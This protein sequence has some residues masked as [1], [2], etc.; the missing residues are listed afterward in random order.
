MR[1]KTA[2]SW[3][4]LAFLILPACTGYRGLVEEWKEYK[5]PEFYEAQVA[6][7][8]EAGIPPTPPGVDFQK[9]VAQLRE[10]KARWEKT[11]EETGAEQGF[12]TPDPD[13]LK[14]LRPASTDPAAAEKNLSDGFSLE[15]LETLAFLRNPGAK[16]A[17][18]DLRA[19]LEEYS[20]VWNLDEIL[21]QYSA[22]TEALMTG[23]GPMKGQEPVELKFPFPGVLALKGEIVTQE[24]KGMN[25]TLE[26]ARRTAVTMARQA[27]WNLHYLHRAQEI[28]REMVSLLTRL[29]AVASARYE[30]GKA[31][32][33]DVIKV[34][35]EREILEEDLNTLRQEEKN[36]KVKVLEVL[37][38][39]AT[40]KVG[41][42]AAR[43]PNRNV[44]PLDPLYGE[45]IQKRQEVLRLR[46]R[47]GKVE[48][49]I[50]LGETQI[51]PA[52]ALNLSLFEDEA[53]TQVGSFRTK[54][55]FSETTKASVGAGLPKTPWYGK[56]DA[57]LRETRQKLAALREELKKAEEATLFNVREA[58]FRL[59]RA[60]REEALY[61]GQV[62]KLSQAALEVSTRG[63]ETGSVS[64]ADVIASYMN[65]LKANL[66]LAKERS[67]LGTARA[68]L[69]EAVG[70]GWKK[71]PR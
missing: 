65:W 13:L 43:E 1:K 33:Q 21:R 70:G 46:D 58:W 35:I 4:T 66:F 3:G 50:L 8:P 10:M 20:Q 49:L 37:D 67:D 59:D 22:F 9:E 47:I 6:P 29:E 71:S 12:Y 44:P 55:P 39:P 54:E 30:T 61:A 51:Y 14:T 11:L 41:Q 38:L 27:Y 45:A 31:N 48:R 69:E 2:F 7:K 56:N 18:K 23:I 53:I 42:P 52:Y 25:E 60:K 17:E 57:Y 19:A 5:P 32:F 62:V 28:T 24:V 26:I 40:T 68:Q 36:F 34:L 64:F 63:Y 15:T 16:A